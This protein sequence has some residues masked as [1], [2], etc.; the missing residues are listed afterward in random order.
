MI[1]EDSPKA[2]AELKKM[3]IHTVMLTGD[4]EITAAAIAEQ[5]GVD[6][7]VA[8]VKPDGKESVIRKLMEHGTVTMVGKDVVLAD[9]E[10]S[11]YY[12]A[13]GDIENK[14]LY[15]RDSNPGVIGA[16][17]RVEGRI[18]T[19]RKRI[20]VYLLEKLNLY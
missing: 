18:I 10:Y 8:S 6:E 9:G 5:A 4:N 11:G 14:T 13:E 3:G 16:G 12:V 17:M 2:I 7:V 19:Q 20:I 15:D 1:K